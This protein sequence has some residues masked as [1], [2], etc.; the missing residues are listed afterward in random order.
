MILGCF[1]ILGVAIS[2]T[3]N[4]NSM[5]ILAKKESGKGPLSSLFSTATACPSKLFQYFCPF[6]IGL[7]IFLQLLQHH[8]SFVCQRV[9]RCR[10]RFQAVPHVVSCGCP[11]EDLKPDF[12]DIRW[13]CRGCVHLVQDWRS[14]TESPIMKRGQVREILNTSRESLK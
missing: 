12:F 9:N 4:V 8:W 10:W 14:K 13:E 3:R 11:S 5:T 2:A 6:D 7:I 1:R